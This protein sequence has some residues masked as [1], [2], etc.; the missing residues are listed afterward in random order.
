MSGTWSAMS[1]PW[2]SR[3]TRT[4][5]GACAV[6]GDCRRRCRRGAGGGV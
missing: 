2:C 1:T 6:R 3:S 4:A 5:V